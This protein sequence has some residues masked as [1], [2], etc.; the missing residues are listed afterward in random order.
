MRNLQVWLVEGGVVVEQDIQ[1]D[2]ARALRKGLVAAHV[3][4]DLP[5]S[6]QEL[7]RRK[8]GFRTEGGVEEPGLIE[9]VDGFGFV[10]ARD[11]FDANGV[12]VEEMDGFAEVVGAVAD[13]GA[14]GD[15]DDGHWSYFRAEEGWRGRQARIMIGRAEFSHSKR[16]RL[17]TW[18]AAVRRPYKDW[19]TIGRLKYGSRAMAAMNR[20]TP[21]KAG[22]VKPPLQTSRSVSDRI[23]TCRRGGGECLGRSGLRGVLARWQRR[24]RA[25]HRR[26]APE[27]R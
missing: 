11:F 22:G 25:R 27:W 26:L 6:G 7:M 3:G 4:F 8:S 16:T 14:E 12:A 17:R 1:V 13:V 23:R 15:V 18:G 21:E 24:R 19:E 10:E 5:E 9:V 20:C 2:E